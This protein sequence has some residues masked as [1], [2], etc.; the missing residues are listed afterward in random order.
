MGKRQVVKQN[1][2]IIILLSLLMVGGLF[3]INLYNDKLKIIPHWNFTDEQIIEYGPFWISVPA[4]ENDGLDTDVNCFTTDEEPD[5]IYLVLPSYIDST[6]V[7]FYVRDGYISEYEARRVADFSNGDVEIAGKKLRLVSTDI[8]VIFLEAGNKAMSFAEF[9]D[10]DRYDNPSIDGRIWLNGHVDGQK[11]TIKARG[12][13][14]WIGMHKKPYSIVFKTDVDLLGMGKNKSYNLIADAWDKT[15][16]KNYTFNQLSKDMGLK[17]EPEMQHVVVYINGDFEGVYLLTTK[18]GKNATSDITKELKYGDF[19]MNWGGMNEAQTIDFTCKDEAMFA[20][21][22]AENA[23]AGQLIPHIGLVYPERVT[24]KDTK[25]KREIIQRY[26]DTVEEVSSDKYLDYLDIDSFMKFYWI[27]EASMNVDAT[28]RS[29]YSIYKADTEKI[30]YEP[31][32]DMDLTLGAT[33]EEPRYEFLNQW[34]VRN[35]GIYKALFSHDGFEKLSEDAYERF[36]VYEKLTDSVE[37]YRQERD[38]IS[39]LGELDFRTWKDEWRG[40]GDMSE[41]T[42]YLQYTD[43]VMEMYMSRIEWIDGQIRK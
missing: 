9:K 40:D 12:N 41:C 31:L 35:K 16:L 42:S 36:S 1:S 23:E 22:N 30:Y 33:V 17:Y 8:P 26:I 18:V 32:W 14:T 21:E 27:Q 15:L 43:K 2:V 29:I 34:D 38:R 10:A 4:R 6:N 11:V 3:C 5:V 28:A 25:K 20:P 24:K 13:T 19:L 39:E 7:V 37:T